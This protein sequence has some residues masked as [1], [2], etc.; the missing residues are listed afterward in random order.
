MNGAG[1]ARADAATVFR[2]GQ[3]ELF[4]QDPEKGRRR[5]DDDTLAFTVDEKL[6]RR[7]G[8][9]VPASTHR[10][11]ASTNSACVIGGR[12]REVPSGRWPGLNAHRTTGSS[13]FS[14][15]RCAPSS[16]RKTERQTALLDSTRAS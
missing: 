11:V 5:I 9:G 6:E 1:A 8:H 15:K 2:P 3:L 12:A 16:T 13:S 7:Y 14:F 10:R 4:A